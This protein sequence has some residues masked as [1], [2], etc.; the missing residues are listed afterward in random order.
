MFVSEVFQSLQGEGRYAGHPSLFVRTSG[1]NLRCVWCDTP[2][3]SW[4][5]EGEHIDVATVLERLSAWT[6]VEHVVITGGEP[7]LQPDLRDL[8]V[9]LHQRGHVITIETAATTFVA[10]L[11][12]DLY[13]LSPKLSNS[14]PGPEQAAAQALHQRNNVHNHVP[15]FLALDG[16]VQVKFVV[17]GAQDLPEIR[18]CVDAW[19]LDQEQVYLMP[20]AAEE[21]GL[22]ERSRVVAQICRDEGFNFTGR[23]QIELWGN[24]RG[25]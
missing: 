14:R 4:H 23:M 12:P 7:L 24:E 16:D 11:H 9:E 10:D 6:D 25:T 19:K 17:E 8:V 20:Q 18:R 13:S 21:A 22:I 15:R 2:H 1:C 5:A 3:T